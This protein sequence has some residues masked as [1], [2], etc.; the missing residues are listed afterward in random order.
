MIVGTGLMSAIASGIIIGNIILPGFGVPLGY[1]AGIV[2][3]GICLA[4]TEFGSQ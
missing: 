1:A 4:K 2:G 3:Y